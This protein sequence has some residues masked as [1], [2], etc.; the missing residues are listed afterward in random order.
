M[1]CTA[2]KQHNLC[3]RLRSGAQYDPS[4]SLGTENEI[5]N[6]E[7]SRDRQ[8]DRPIQA[9]AQHHWATYSYH[10][11]RWPRNSATFVIIDEIGIELILGF[12]YIETAVDEIH[13]RKR[14]LVLIKLKDCDYTKTLRSRTRCYTSIS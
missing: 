2:A 11:D 6:N 10:D 13:L 3:P 9:Q 4:R 8:F 5:K 1:E 7:G 14:A 12:K